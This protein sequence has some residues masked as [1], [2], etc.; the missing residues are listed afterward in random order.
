MTIVFLE[1]LFLE[2]VNQSEAMALLTR[3]EAIAL[4]DCGAMLMVPSDPIWQVRWWLAFSGE[5]STSAPFKDNHDNQWI[6]TDMDNRGNIAC[7]LR[8][9]DGASSKE[10]QRGHAKCCQ[11]HSHVCRLWSPIAMVTCMKRLLKN[12][13]CLAKS[14]M[15]G[16]IGERLRLHSLRVSRWKQSTGSWPMK[17]WG[18]LCGWGWYISQKMGGA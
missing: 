11:L 3:C 2:N 18:E 17:C 5:T 10:V 15:V 9:F 4:R 13:R 8:G 6:W 16:S 7:D 14:W 1:L 12:K